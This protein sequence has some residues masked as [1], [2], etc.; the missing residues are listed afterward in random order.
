MFGDGRDGAR[1]LRCGKTK[2]E[3][4]V[5]REVAAGGSR[6]IRHVAAQFK[7]GVR[8]LRILRQDPGADRKVGRAT[9]D[10]RKGFLQVEI[11]QIAVTA[12]HSIC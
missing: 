3:P 6:V 1:L 5:R 9:G 10:Q 8:L 11:A 7:S 2:D 4:S 12:M